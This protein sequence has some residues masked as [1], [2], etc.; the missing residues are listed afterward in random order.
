MINKIKNFFYGLFN[1]MDA[2]EKE[3]STTSKDKDKTVPIERQQETNS[4]ADAMLKGV[5]TEE[6][7]EMRYR[8]YKV[9]R[10]SEHYSYIGNG[11][12]VK[13]DDKLK[14]HYRGSL[15]GGSSDVI[16]VQDNTL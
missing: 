9:S 7:K 15:Y 1:G 10:N 2:A 3:I 11:L 4:M 6:L 13:K 12:A 8:D 14:P 5:V 16:L